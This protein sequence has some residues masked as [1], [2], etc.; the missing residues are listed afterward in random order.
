MKVKVNNNEVETGASNLLLLSHQL[1]LP[2]T[3]I[4]VA[5]NNRIVPR[6]QWG[7]CPILQGDSLIII[8][9]VCGG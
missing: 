3:G 4:A 9:A 1:N 8:K 6:A 2:P 5:V 7:D